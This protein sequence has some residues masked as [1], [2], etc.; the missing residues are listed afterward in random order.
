MCVC[1]CVCVPVALHSVL[2]G[3]TF[4]EDP[5]FMKQLADIMRKRRK[6]RMTIEVPQSPRIV[7]LA[8]IMKIPSEFLM[9]KLHVLGKRKVIIYY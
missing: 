3:L 2:R 8:S 7:D 5:K 6:K 4:L 1:V 9:H